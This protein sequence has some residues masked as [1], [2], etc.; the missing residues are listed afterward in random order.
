MIEVLWWAAK[1]L[2]WLGICGL[3]AFGAVTLWDNAKE[4][5]R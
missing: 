5:R 4:L 1:A 3:A 2:V